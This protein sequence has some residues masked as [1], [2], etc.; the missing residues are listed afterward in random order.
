MEFFVIELTQEDWELNKIKTLYIV[1]GRSPREGLERRE[2][3]L[4]G[5]SKE[6]VGCF[7]RYVGA[8]VNT[9]VFHEIYATSNH[10]F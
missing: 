3:F 10:R 4:S 2:F 6:G 1:M 5:R 9:S 7:G 8:F